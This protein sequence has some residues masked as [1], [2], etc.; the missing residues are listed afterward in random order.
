M[1]TS[2]RGMSCPSIIMQVH[3][4]SPTSPR[5]FPASCMFCLCARMI[6]GVTISCRSITQRRVTCGVGH[7]ITIAAI[8][9]AVGAQR[10][11]AAI[12]Q[13]VISALSSEEV[14][15]YARP[16]RRG[17]MLQSQALQMRGAIPAADYILAIF[18]RRLHP[19]PNVSYHYRS[20]A[21]ALIG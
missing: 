21:M 7:V 17:Q 6:R 14:C 19:P 15:I 4:L 11:V 20:A 2:R 3:N 18:L 8:H 10:S 9:G 13:T 16:P 5:P 12:R 1:I